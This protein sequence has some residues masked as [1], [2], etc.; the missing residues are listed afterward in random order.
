MK[1]PSLA[2][3]EKSALYEDWIRDESVGGVLSRYMPNT[4]VRVY[5]KDSIMK[6]YGREKIKDF[7]PIAKALGI[8]SDS[9]TVERYIKPHG[10]RMADGKVICWG[11]SR[12]WKSILFAAFERAHLSDSAA[13]Y[14]AAIM[15]P[16]GKCMQPAYRAMV[17][18]AA[19]KLG[20]CQLLW[21]ED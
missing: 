19:R 7:G 8:E 15:Y 6:P 16:K 4:S 3:R 13:P 9:Q 12:E 10:R 17:E 11:L 20:I 18:S 14:G 21:W 2:D 5:L 1:W